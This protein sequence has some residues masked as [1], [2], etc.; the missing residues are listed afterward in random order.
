MWRSTVAGAGIF[1]LIALIWTG[2]DPMLAQMEVQQL[3]SEPSDW[4]AARARLLRRG[5]GAVLALRGSLGSTEASRRLRC[6]QSLGLLGEDEADEILMESLQASSDAEALMA[7]ELIREL[8][9]LRN[10]PPENEVKELLTED[11]KRKESLDLALTQY[12]AWTGGY[13]ARARRHLAEEEARL[14]VRD[15]LSA[16]LLEPEQ[17]DALVI[18][19][20]GYAK[21][22][23]SEL[24]VD[25][26]R[27][28]VRINPRIEPD[29][30]EELEVLQ[31]AARKERERRLRRRYQNLPLV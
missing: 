10:G 8:W 14:A 11:T 20:R 16:L 3:G 4:R 17:F 28:A 30:A 15:A 31:E 2:W 25:C 13:V 23:F 26:L 7:M 6:A 27:Q 22:G 1:F 5:R 24:G 19:G 9:N 29:L 12:Y 18:L 21:L